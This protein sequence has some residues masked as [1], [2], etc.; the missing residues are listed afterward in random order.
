MMRGVHRYGVIREIEV[1]GP[2]ARTELSF[3]CKPKS[4]SPTDRRF[5]GAQFL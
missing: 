4:P 5:Y 2:F 3:T 1:W